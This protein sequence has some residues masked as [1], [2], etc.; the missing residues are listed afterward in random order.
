MPRTIAIGDIHGCSAALAALVEA[1]DPQADDT[2][3]TLGDYIDRGPDSRSVIELLLRLQ[4]RCRLLPLVGNH[5]IIFFHVQSNVEVLDFWLNSC[6]GTATLASYRGRFEH[7]PPEH[8]R[9]LQQLLPFHE[10]ETHLFVHANY[11]PSLPLCE[12]SEQ[13]LYWTHLN[14][15]PAPHVSGKQAIV[16][17]TPQTSGAIL[18]AGHL[19][20]IDTWCFGSGALT[21]YD[22][23]TG[24]IWQADKGGVL[25]RGDHP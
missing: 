13:V 7:I 24:H 4:D 2:I 15:I 22:V 10:S 1:I 16:G 25:L 8:W 11:T 9:F 21:A 17:H 6:G 12:Q 19:V 14:T 23:D 20:C 18:H 5:E 3:I